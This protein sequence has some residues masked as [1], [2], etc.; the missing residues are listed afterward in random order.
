MY[1]VEFNDVNNSEIGIYATRPN[2][3]AANRKKTS[4]K[5]PGRDGEL[6]IHENS[7]EDIVISI[8]FGFYCEQ[9]K[10][11]D[12]YRKAKKWLLTK[13][14]GKLVLSDDPDFFYKVK[15]VYIG[16][17]ER[18]VKEIGEFKADFICDGFQYLKSGLFEYGKEDV[19]YNPFSLSKPIYKI[20]G[21]GVCELTVNGKTVRANIGQN[22]VID[23]EKMIAYRNDGTLQNT[24]ITGD[25]EDLYLQECDNSIS[26]T[27]GFALKVIPNWRC[28]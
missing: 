17:A 1:Y 22:I 24:K 10:W 4:F 8:K 2:L 18:T 15:S 27:S 7:V 3:P 13:I 25:Y 11:M 6:Y 19:L 14:S 5:I 26:I 12:Y 23:T 21:E 16:T 20:T 9:S 28:L